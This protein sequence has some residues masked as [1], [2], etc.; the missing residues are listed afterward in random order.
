[1]KLIWISNYFDKNIKKVQYKIFT[2]SK[3]GTYEVDLVKYFECS[4]HL[5]LKFVWI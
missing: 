3:F 4:T 1:M 5:T 2:K